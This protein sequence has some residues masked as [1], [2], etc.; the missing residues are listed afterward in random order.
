MQEEDFFNPYRAPTHS[1]IHVCHFTTGGV[2]YEN[3]NTD[4]LTFNVTGVVLKCFKIG[5][6][7][8]LRSGWR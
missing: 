4:R 3:V 7:P 6:Q 2:S 5:L 1:L 8:D